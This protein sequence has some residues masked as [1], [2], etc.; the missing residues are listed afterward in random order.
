M[1]QILSSTL[2]FK[3]DPLSDYL[4]P[5]KQPVPLSLFFCLR[6]GGLT[7]LLKELLLLDDLLAE[8]HEHLLGLL[9]EAA[10]DGLA[11]ERVVDADL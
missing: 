9:V 7:T 6:L 4:D 3:L 11:A 10:L 2:C 8:H 1:Q 5:L